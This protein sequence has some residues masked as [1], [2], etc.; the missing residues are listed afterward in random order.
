VALDEMLLESL[1]TFEDPRSGIRERFLTPVIG[2]Q[3]TVCVLSSPTGRARDMGWVICHSFAMEQIWLQPLEVAA[4]RRLS[5]AGFTVLRFHSQ[6][7]GDSEGS[8]AE[9]GLETHVRDATDAIQ[10]LREAGNVSRLGLMGGRVGGTVAALAADRCDAESLILWEPIVDGRGFVEKL[11]RGAM[12]TE[13]SSAS[14][15]KARAGDVERNFAEAGVLDVQG[16]PLSSAAFEEFSAFDLLPSITHFT[17]EALIVQI[18]RTPRVRVELERLNTRL[19]EIGGRSSL[20]VLVDADGWRFGLQ[21][22]YAASN[23]RRKEDKQAALSEQLVSLSLSWCLREGEVD[24]IK[25][26]VDR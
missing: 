4:A 8:T 18:S 2:G 7:Y 16:F 11:T 26:H 9:I 20:H 17:G 13:L 21:R 3:R 10:V 19:S 22:Y 25:E 6:G 15:V 12:V 14:Q 5:A 23:G 24:T 1:R